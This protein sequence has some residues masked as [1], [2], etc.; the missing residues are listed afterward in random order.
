MIWR[1]FVLIGTRR[2]VG[3]NVKA[4]E[5]LGGKGIIELAW[6]LSVFYIQLQF[7]VLTLQNI[8]DLDMHTW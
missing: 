4:G 7:A 3:E 6:D 1:W 8:H 5:D 2:R